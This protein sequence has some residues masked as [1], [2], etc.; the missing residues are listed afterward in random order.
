MV[1][2]AVM[3]KMSDEIHRLF[4]TREK[5]DEW[6]A[7]Y[8]DKHTIVEVHED[9]LRFNDPELPCTWCI[10][11]DLDLYDVLDVYRGTNQYKPGKVKVWGRNQKKASV[12]VEA[13]TRGEAKEKALALLKEYKLSVEK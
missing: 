3:K 5:L 9:V 6:M 7:D 12:Y 11:M 8:G 13:L 4:L 1:V 2:Y 10:T